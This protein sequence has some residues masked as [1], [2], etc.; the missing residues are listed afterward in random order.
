AT[1]SALGSVEAP[2]PSEAHG[3][4]YQRTFVGR[5]P[6]LAQLTAAFDGALSGQG[7]IAMVVGEPGIGKTSLVEQ[8]ATYVALRGGR[9]LWGHCYEEGSLAL[10]YLAFV[11]ALR[12]YVLEREPEAL[13]SE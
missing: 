8:L 9:A 3:G 6:E 5:E 11:E 10:P 7:A 4:L 1:R 13:R 2:S 12:G